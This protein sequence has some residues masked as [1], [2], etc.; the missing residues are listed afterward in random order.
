MAKTQQNDDINVLT[1]VEMS[2]YTFSQEEL[3]EYASY[4]GIDLELERD[5]LWV[6]AEGLVAVPP[7]PWKACQ[8]S[9][10]SEVFFFN[11]VTGE[12]V[13]D[14]PCDE[15]T[16]QKVI[17]EREKRALVP[18]TLSA[19]FHE[20]GWLISG[21]TLAGTTICQATAKA[22]GSDDFASIE[23]ELRSTLR[24]PEGAV[25]RFVLRDASM[26]GHSSRSR[27]VTELF[28]IAA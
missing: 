8:S 23:D 18:I 11:F 9:G 27:R 6:A 1:D 14:H 3:E 5:L 26:L 19:E 16:R 2:D 4:V 15:L 24:L 17:A 13:W 22:P 12:S 20:E 28:A 25:P 7:E 21:V 10:E